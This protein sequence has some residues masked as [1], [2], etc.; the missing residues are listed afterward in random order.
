MTRLSKNIFYNLLG[1]VLLLVLSFISAKYIFKQLGEEALGI[2]YFTIIMNVLLRTVLEMGVCSTTVRE[3]SAHFSSEP[4]YIHNLIRTTSLFYWLIYVMAGLAIYLLAPVLVEKWINLKTMDH[5]I[6]IYTLRVL[7][8]SSVLALPKSLYSSIFQ[9]LQRMEFT[10]FIEVS[11]SALQQLGAVLFLIFGGGLLHIVHWFA[12]IYIIR[13]F[14]YLAALTRFFPLQAFIPC[15]FHDVM[16]RIFAFASR[17]TSVSITASIYM[18]ADKLIISKLL[19]I[20]AVGYYGFAYNSVSKGMLL[21]DSVLLA[22]FPSLAELSKAGDNEKLTALYRKLQDLLYLATVP[23][24]AA[25][26]FAAIPLF[27]YVFNTETAKSLLLPTTFLSVGF[28]MNGTVH[29]PFA[30]SQAVGKPGITARTSLYAL[31]VVLPVTTILIY[32]FGL[33]GAGLSWILYHLFTYS[34]GIPR[35]F[36]ECLSMSLWRWYMY[37]LKIFLLVGCT[38]GV[39]WIILWLIGNYSIPYLAAAYLLASAAFLTRAYSM[40]GSELKETLLGYFR[41]LRLSFA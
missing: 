10:N 20:G 23:I 41:Q 33:V 14:I 34:Y 25:I 7:G 29:L 24:F 5:S 26:P 37:V 35:V 28:Y 15:Y 22:A 32:F 38:Y 4:D 12:A 6:A 21:K 8:I 40:I 1:Q 9:G 27:S 3:V 39:A 16:K 36:A 31:F 19:P 2:I 18:Q 11:T 13:V 17:M 30:L